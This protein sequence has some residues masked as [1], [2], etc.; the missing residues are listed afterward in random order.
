MGEST[1]EVA[2]KSRARGRNHLACSAV[3][4]CL[5]HRF[6]LSTTYAYQLHFFHSRAAGRMTIPRAR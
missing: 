1:A 5:L 4:A 3:A 2:V 6:V